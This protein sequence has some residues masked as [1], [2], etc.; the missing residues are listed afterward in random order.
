KEISEAQK[1][2]V[3]KVLNG[4]LL[5]DYEWW[6]KRIPH[7]SAP[8]Q[9]MNLQLAIPTLKQLS[10]QQYTTIR[11]AIRSLIDA[12]H[13]VELN[14]FVI[15][16][17]VCRQLDV[18][19]GLRRPSTG[20]GVMDLSMFRAATVVFSR[21]A[22][23]GSADINIQRKAFRHGIQEFGVA[24]ADLLQPPMCENP[25]LQNALTRL[26]TLD[27][28]WKR[29]FLRACESVIMYDHVE[30]DGEAVLFYGISATLGI[31]N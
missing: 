13:V 18:V 5:S 17:M 21:L 4:I 6:L 30:T 3:Q 1:K 19:F 11:T 12:D 24:D 7:M 28:N 2:T 26:D 23:A 20:N 22:Y 8:E 16:S 10:P 27:I 29:H 15:Y 9:L 25:L 31:Y 14:E